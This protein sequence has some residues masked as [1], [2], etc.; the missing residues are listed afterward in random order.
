MLT[1]RLRARFRDDDVPETELERLAEASCASEMDKD[2]ERDRA[3]DVV[4][5]DRTE[6]GRWMGLGLD[7][8]LE[9]EVVVDDRVSLRPELERKRA[10]FAT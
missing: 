2:R 5:P 7:L 10:E 6:D 9:A 8:F 1:S 3:S 4:A